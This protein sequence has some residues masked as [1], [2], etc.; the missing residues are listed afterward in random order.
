MVRIDVSRPYRTGCV[1]VA[2]LNGDILS[3]VGLLAELVAVGIGP[4]VGGVTETAGSGAN[5]GADGVM[6]GV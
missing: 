3:T 4:T 2:E 6:V 1:Y 5:T